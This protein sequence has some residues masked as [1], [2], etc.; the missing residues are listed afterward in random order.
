MQ[1]LLQIYVRNIIASHK[2]VASKSLIM[3]HFAPV[4]GKTNDGNWNWLIG[5]EGNSLT[6]SRIVSLK[7]GS[8]RFQKILSLYEGGP[9]LWSLITC[10]T[11]LTHGISRTQ[12]APL[13][14]FQTKRFRS[15]VKVNCWHY[16]SINSKFK[17]QTHTVQQI[18]SCKISYEE[19]LNYDLI[20]TST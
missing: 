4:E 3:F 6:D 9:G 1:L 7:V 17:L 19:I 15:R 12:I 5:F 11:Y 8:V 10:V 13:L 20:I 16:L 18:L 2:L 14:C